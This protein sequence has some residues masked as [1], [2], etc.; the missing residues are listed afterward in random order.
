MAVNTTFNKF[1]RN[2]VERNTVSWE[3]SGKKRLPGGEVLNKESLPQIF[4]WG[5]LCF[6]SK[7]T[8]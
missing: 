8:L 7:K 4:A 1:I 2:I 3:G 6:L 5:V